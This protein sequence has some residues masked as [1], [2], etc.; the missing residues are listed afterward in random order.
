M[1]VASSQMGL[2][3][4]ISRPNRE[5]I[6]EIPGI[7]KEIF[8]NYFYNST[9]PHIYVHEG[10]LIRRAISPSARRAGSTGSLSVLDSVPSFVCASEDPFV[11]D[12]L[13]AKHESHGTKGF[14]KTHGRSI[15][16]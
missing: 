12:I 13:L 11:K 2:Q 9:R 5:R 10:P 3:S 16:P 4:D 1:F 8:E 15:R 14:H 7:G 6:W